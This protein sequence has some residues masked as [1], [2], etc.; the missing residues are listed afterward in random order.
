MQVLSA[1]SPITIVLPMNIT[2]IIEP[3]AKVAGLIRGISAEPN[4]LDAVCRA[5]V[6]YTQM[7]QVIVPALAL[8][9]TSCASSTVGA[10]AR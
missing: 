5:A 7:R 9:L 10:S 1:A 8:A 2:A 3:T 6:P 4:R